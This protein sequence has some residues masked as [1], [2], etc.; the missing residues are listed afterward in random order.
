MP[1]FLGPAHKNQPDSTRKGKVHIQHGCFDIPAWLGLEAISCY[2]MPQL[3]NRPRLVLLGVAGFRGLKPADDSVAYLNDVGKQ[4][5]VGKPAVK[6]DET[7]VNPIAEASLQHLE[8]ELS[9]FAKGL[10]APYHPLERLSSERTVAFGR[11]FE[12]WNAAALQQQ[13]LSRELFTEYR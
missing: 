11:F 13:V 3:S 9:L 7:G 4:T 12:V 8:Q 1:L 2:L 5:I 10:L 6:E